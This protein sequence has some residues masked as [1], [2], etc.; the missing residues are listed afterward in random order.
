[1]LPS[2]AGAALAWLHAH[3]DVL[4]EEHEN[5]RD[6]PQVHL[7]VRMAPADHE[8]FSRLFGE[9]SGTA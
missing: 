7:S 8:R 9:N 1:M 5:E 3:G 2:S 6:S 4:S